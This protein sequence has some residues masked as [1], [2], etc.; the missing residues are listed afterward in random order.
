MTIRAE[1]ITK[2][3]GDFTALEDVSVEVADGSL[4]ALLGPSGSGKSTLLRI[5]AG[6]EMPDAGTGHDRRRRRHERRA[7]EAR[8]RLRLPALR[9]VQ[10]PHGAPQRRVRARDPQAA[11]GRDPRARRRAARA[12]AAQRLRRP[13]SGAALGRPAPAHGA[14]ARA[15]HRAERAAARRAVRRARRDRAQGAARVAAA[16]ARG[17]AR[18]D[19]PRHAR[20][21]GG[22]G[23]GRPDRRHEPRARSSR[24]AIRARSTTT[25][26]T[27]S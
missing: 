5:I 14:R 11:E 25:R 12:R 10:A 3:F 19:D 22:H 1:H 23:R 7:A 17:D 2:R 20:S 6:L 9:R 13:L 15:R 4:T 24:R 8:H 16:A 18:D 26:P 21:G 27:S